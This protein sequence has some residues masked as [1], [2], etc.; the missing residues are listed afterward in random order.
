M[1]SKATRSS[2]LLAGIITAALAAH[3]PAPA[4]Q[5]IQAARAWAIAI[6][7]ALSGVR[8]VVESGAMIR[9]A[10]ELSDVTPIDL[11][12]PPRIRPRSADHRELS[13]AE[14]RELQPRLPAGVEVCDGPRR[15]CTA[16]GQPF[17]LFRLSE[18]SSSADE[19]FV[20]IQTTWVRA[21]DDHALCETWV[22]SLR[23]NDHDEW[24]IVDREL[25]AVC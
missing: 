14:V 24:G 16:N 9:I 7:D 4:Q 22:L 3:A 19:A 13:A 1:I 23:P 5:P 21:N 25:G 17:V 6:Q 11:A 15:E 12:D 8:D 2:L 10:R 18:V 20:S